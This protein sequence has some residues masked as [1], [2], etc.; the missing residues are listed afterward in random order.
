MIIVLKDSQIEMAALVV[1]SL[2]EQ[3]EHLNQGEFSLAGDVLTL[4]DRAEINF[5]YALGFYE[6]EGYGEATV[7]RN[8]IEN[9]ENH[10]L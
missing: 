10:P 8:L 9:S 5:Y 2:K 1:E 7:L 4:D 6:N 3:G